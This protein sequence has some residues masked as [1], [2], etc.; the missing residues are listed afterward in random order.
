MFMWSKKYLSKTC[1][2]VGLAESKPQSLFHT[3]GSNGFRFFGVENPWPFFCAFLWTAHLPCSNLKHASWNRNFKA[4]LWKQEISHSCKG[5]KLPICKCRCLKNPSDTLQITP[6]LDFFVV[7]LGACGST[8]P[9]M[10]VWVTL[11]NWKFAGAIFHRL[12]HPGARGVHPNYS[13]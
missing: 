5:Q 1:G 13:R 11:S 6:P 7:R 10:N 8:Y 2:G 4:R 3:S 12:I 9:T